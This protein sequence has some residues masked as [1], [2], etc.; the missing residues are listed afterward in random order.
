[1]DQAP[2][3][4]ALYMP[5]DIFPMLCSCMLYACWTLHLSNTEDLSMADAAARSSSSNT[6]VD[7]VLKNQQV[8][9][10]SIKVCI[11]A[12]FETSMQSPWNLQAV[13]AP[14]A[15]YQLRCIISVATVAAGLMMYAC[16]CGGM[17]LRC[18]WTGPVQPVYVSISMQFTQ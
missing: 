17:E 9:M 16:W 11:D 15:A 6:T 3:C 8:G 1:M 18:T 7:A 2:V 14:R 13:G 12:V 4:C 10:G 5:D